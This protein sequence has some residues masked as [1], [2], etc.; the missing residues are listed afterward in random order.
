MLL[1]IVLFKKYRVFNQRLILY[2]AIAS[3]LQP[4]TYFFD[5]YDLA[6]DQGWCRFMGI[7]TQYI[8]WVAV[9]WISCITFT[10]CIG[11][12]LYKPTD[13]LEMYIHIYSISSIVQVRMLELFF[14][15]LHSPYHV[16]CWGIP[17]ILAL[18]PLIE[19]TYGLAGL[20]CW[21]R[22]S[23]NDE[24]LPLGIAFQFTLYYI[25]I[26]II[27]ILIVSMSMTVVII[28]HRRAKKYQGNYNPN[29]LEEIKT[30]QKEMR[31]LYFYPWAFALLY[32][33]PFI[34]RF[35]IAVGGTHDVIP[36]G[37]SF[38]LWLLHANTLPMLG[39]VYTVIF[40]LDKETR[41]RLTWSNIKSAL[42]R[43]NTSSV[44][45]PYSIDISVEDKSKIEPMTTPGISNE[46]S[47][48]VSTIHAAGDS[49]NGECSKDIV[50]ENSHSAD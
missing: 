48:V 13:K 7:M 38:V 41:S 12:V 3:I 44:A 23:I 40:A 19:L 5:S 33:I 43:K 21:I 10:V 4:L 1:M 25:P 29:K 18:I 28:I 47:V 36:V 9:L 35:R 37:L 20:W 22:S 31:S 49:S 34:N 50:I 8:D 2:L 45:K 17:V 11:A 26:A 30:L 42:L 32:T 27:A 24:P 15:C 39:T 6:G 14:V 46:E 16:I